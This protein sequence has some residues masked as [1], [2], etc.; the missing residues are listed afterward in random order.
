M[1]RAAVEQALRSCDLAQ[2]IGRIDLHAARLG[3][4]A[5]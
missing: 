5:S 3:Y 2:E 1:V 4:R